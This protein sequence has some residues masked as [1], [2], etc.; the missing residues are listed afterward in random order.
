MQRLVEYCRD[1][2]N[3]LLEQQ[4]LVRVACVDDRGIHRSVAVAQILKAVCE[5]KGYNTLGPVHMEEPR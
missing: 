3:S 4:D 5:M 1:G 2:V